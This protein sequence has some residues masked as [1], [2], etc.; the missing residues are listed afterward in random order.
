M[1]TVDILLPKLVSKCL[2]KALLVWICYQY[3]VAEWLNCVFDFLVPCPLV[4]LQAIQT[5]EDKMNLIH[6]KS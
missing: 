6:S 2:K 3:S 4:I 5:S 1:L